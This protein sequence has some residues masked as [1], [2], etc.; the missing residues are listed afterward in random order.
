VILLAL[1]ADGEKI[2]YGLILMEILVNLIKSWPIISEF[3]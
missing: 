3:I 2:S 1:G